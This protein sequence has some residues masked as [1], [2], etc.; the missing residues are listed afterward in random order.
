MATASDYLENKLLEAALKNT[1]Y[2]GGTVYLAAY[3]DTFTDEA[4]APTECSGSGY[5]RQS[6]TFGS[7]SNGVIATSAAV[8]IPATADYA[9]KAI[10]IVDASTGGN[11]LFYRNVTTTVKSGGLTLDSGNITVT[12]D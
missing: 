6:L 9:V 3:T 10:A 11:V 12:L 2:S 8:T 1:S 4:S 7:A 5:S